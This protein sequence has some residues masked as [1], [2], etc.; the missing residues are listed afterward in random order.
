MVLPNK[1][2]DLCSSRP[3]SHKEKKD[4]WVIVQPT[5]HFKHLIESMG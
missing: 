2:F 3:G 1:A 5:H 4:I